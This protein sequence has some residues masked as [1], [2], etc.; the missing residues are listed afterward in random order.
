MADKEEAAASASAAAK[1]A[2]EAATAATGAAASANF[3][4][5]R[6]DWARW[7]LLLNAL[8]VLPVATQQLKR[9]IRY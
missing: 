6:G 3:G 4:L 7:G 9:F 2:G 8:I 1:S 5:S